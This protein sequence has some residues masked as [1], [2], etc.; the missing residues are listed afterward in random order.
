MISTNKN[1]Y[2]LGGENIMYMEGYYGVDSIAIQ[3]VDGWMKS[4]GHRANIL[5]PYFQNEGIGVAKSG[6]EIYVTQNFC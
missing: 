3:T 6:N 5:T 4:P 2:S 1:Q